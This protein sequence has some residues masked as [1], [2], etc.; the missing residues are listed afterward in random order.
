MR[1]LTCD[2]LSVSYGANQVLSD[3]SFFCGERRVFKHFG[4]KRRRQVHPFKMSAGA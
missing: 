1:I 3:L 2:N 4:R